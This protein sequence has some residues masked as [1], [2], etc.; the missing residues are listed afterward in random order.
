MV[1]N[2]WVWLTLIRVFHHLAN[3]TADSAKF[4]SAQPD[5]QAH[6]VLSIHITSQLLSISKG[7]SLLAW[8][9]A[10]FQEGDW[11]SIRS[12]HVS[13]KVDE[14]LKVGRFGLGFKSAYHTTGILHYMP[15]MNNE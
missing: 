9:D 6:L 13:N 2:Y 15:L 3:R 1:V 5:H 11:D 7:P 12:M 10:K 14:P 4:P 8:N